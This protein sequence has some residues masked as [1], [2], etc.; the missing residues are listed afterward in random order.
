MGIFEE[1]LLEALADISGKLDRVSDMLEAVCA[2]IDD[3][4]RREQEPAE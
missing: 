4:N 3:L 1:R 2:A